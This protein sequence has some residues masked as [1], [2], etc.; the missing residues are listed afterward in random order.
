MT[1]TAALVLVAAA[2]GACGSD[3]DRGAPENRS[4]TY[5]S[6]ADAICAQANRME[7]AAGAPGPGWIYMPEFDDVK[8]LKRFN[9]PG[10]DAL[11]KLRALEPPAGQRARAATVVASIAQMVQS[12]DGRIADLEAGTG[13]ASDRIKAYLDGYSDLTPAAAV[14]GLSE[15]QGVSL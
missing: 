11:R 4:A 1:R 2:I 15:C 6:K 9:A 13:D 12:L 5:V 7:A 14:L 8:F 3:D 10:H